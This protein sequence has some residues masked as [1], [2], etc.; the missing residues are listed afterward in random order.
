MKI[1]NLGCGINTI[2]GAI[3]VDINP[4]AMADVICDLN[5]FPYPF[6]D[7][8]FDQIY[9]LDIL[10]HL[11][12]VIKSLEEINRIAKN[13]AEI[14]IRV[15][16]FSST[17]AYGDPT[18][19]RAFNTESFNC[20]FDEFPENNFYTGARFQKKEVKIIFWK[21]HKL[22]GISWLANRFMGYYDKLFAF[23]FPAMNLEF[24]LLVRK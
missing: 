12:N 11:D 23:I 6:A 14:Y 21:L 13:N 24:K 22:D 8:V 16:H 15:P 3:A 1:L 5:R 9:C 10:E 20:F 2:E 18:H 17:L 4:R 19:K 7:N